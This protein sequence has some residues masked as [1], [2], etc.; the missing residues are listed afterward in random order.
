MVERPLITKTNSIKCWLNG[1]PHYSGAA[2]KSEILTPY[3]EKIQ[4]F[5]A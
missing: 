3:L 4:A 2:T 5:I 1:A